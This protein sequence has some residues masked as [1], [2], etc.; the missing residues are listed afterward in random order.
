MVKKVLLPALAGLTIL[1]APVSLVG[2]TGENPREPEGF[3][4]RG[5][6]SCQADGSFKI[7]WSVKNREDE[8]MKITFSSNESVVPKGTRIPGNE[9]M[10]FTQTVSGS[11]AANYSLVLRARFIDRNGE[12]HEKEVQWRKDTVKLETACPQP[13]GGQGGGAVL[14]AQVTAP[15]GGVS[16]GG[17]GGVAT[18]LSAV[19]GLTG[20]LAAAGLGLRRLSRF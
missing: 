20:S 15:T 4:L 19:A 6:G 10:D 8:R 13:S 17:G 18:G 12:E 16:A 2:A 3:R 11:T 7:V 14:G 9:T 5:V 1:I